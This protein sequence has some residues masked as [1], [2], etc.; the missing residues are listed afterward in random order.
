MKLRYQLLITLAALV[1]TYFI[2]KSQ[3]EVQTVTKTVEVVK[4]VVVVKKDEKIVVTE[5]PDGTKITIT[6]TKTETEKNTERESNHSSET[7]PVIK[8]WSVGAYVAGIDDRSYVLTADRRI[9]GPFSIGLYG[10]T[11]LSSQNEIGLGLRVE[12]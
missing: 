3:S 9:L 2:G 6:E 8:Q 10:R 5:K 4:E 12:F 7:T 11:D 1:V